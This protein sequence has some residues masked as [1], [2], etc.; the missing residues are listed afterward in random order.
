MA[1]GKPATPL[2]EQFGFNTAWRDAQLTLIGLD[3]AMRDD[4][5]LLQNEVL[6]RDAAS[7]IVDQ[8]FA[9]LVLNPQAAS[10]LSSFDLG[11][12][13]ERQPIISK[14]ALALVWRTRAWVYL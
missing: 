14:A 3:T 12:L 10:I 1:A 5:R 11:H 13:K 7:R 8:F 6:T 2:C 9:Q 4:V